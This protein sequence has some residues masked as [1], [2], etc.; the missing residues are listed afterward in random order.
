MRIGRIGM[1]MLLCLGYISGIYAQTF[2]KL[3]KQVEQAEKKSLPET[4]IKLTDKIYRKGEMEKNSPQ[5]LKAYMWRMKYRERIT[6]DSF[7]ISLK[8]LEEWVKHTDK[9]MDRA[10]LHSLLAGIYAD[11]AAR[12]QW[13]LRQQTDIVGVVPADMLNWTANI[14]VDTIQTHIRKAM[15]DSVL[16]L[17]TSSRT[18]IPFVELGET[19]EYYHHDMYHLLASRSI[20]ALLRVQYLDKQKNVKQHISGLY[21]NMLSAYRGKGDKESYV[22]TSLNF[23]KWKYESNY[24]FYPVIDKAAPY[25]LAE[26]PYIIDLNKLAADYKTLDICAEVLLAK[27]N[28]IL[29]RQQPFTALQVCEEAIRLYPDYR[30]INALKNL[31]EEIL[32][33]FL[34]VS[35]VKTAFPDQE[36]KIKVSHKNL[37]GFTIRIYREKK[38][39]SEQHY[40]VRR[41][42][43]YQSQDTTFTF[44]APGVG[45]YVMRIVP[46]VRAKKEIEKEFNVTHFYV[47]T[48]ELPKEQ[49]E[50][51]TLD[52]RTGHPIS[53]AQ[54]TLYNNKDV[55]LQMFTTN[56][57]GKAIFPWKSDYSYLIATKGDDT[58]MEKKDIRG[59]SFRS[60]DMNETTEKVILL[61]D[62]SL[63]RPGQTVYVK[64]IAYVSELGAARVLSDKEYTVSLQDNNNQEVGKRTLRTNEFGS[65]TTSFTLPLA[66]L[67][68]D[69]QLKTPVGNASIRVE[70]YKRPT[71]DIT[72]E[73]QE[74]D[75]QLGN[76]AEIKGKV[77]SY[78]G[79]LLRDLPVKYTIKR[80]AYSF[81]QLRMNDQ[82]ASGEVITGADGVFTIPVQLEGDTLYNNGKGNYFSYLIEITVTNAAG[83]TQTSTKV[84]SAGDTFLYLRTYLMPKTCKDDPIKLN[85]YASNQ[86]QLA[87]VTV[88]YRLYRAKDKSMKQL[89]DTPVITGTAASNKEIFLDWED[90][91]SGPYV[92][93]ISAE[94]SLGRKGSAETSTILY[95]VHNKRPPIQTPDWYFKTNTEFDA[96]HP[97]VFYFGTSEKDVCVMVDVFSNEAL[98]ESKVLHLSDSI[99]RFEFPYQASYGDGIAVNIYM[100]RD[101]QVYQ[102]RV[103]LSKRSLDEKLDMKWEVFRD[104]LRPGQK[105][106]WKLT[107]KNPQGKGADAEMLATMYDA[108]LDKIWKQGQTFNVFHYRNLPYISWMDNF[109]SSIWFEYEWDKKLFKVPSFEYDHFV[110]VPSSSIPAVVGQGVGEFWI[111]GIA[112][113]SQQNRAK[114]SQKMTGAVLEE[115]VVTTRSSSL[116]DDLAGNVP[117]ILEAEGETISPVTDDIRTNLAETAFFYPQLRTNEQGEVSFSFTMPESLTRWNFRGYSHTKNMMLGTLDGEAVTS[118]EFMLVPNLPR[119][120]RVGDK[121]SIAASISN[122]TGKVQSGTVSMILFDPM[123][124]K[125]ISTR[126]QEFKVEAGATIGVSFQF[127]VDD[128]YSILGCRMIADSKMFSDGEQQLIP[129]L[130]NKEHLIETLPMPIRGEETRTFSLDSLFNHHSATATDRKLTI[131]FTGNPSWY[132]IQ[133]LPSLSLPTNDNAISWANAYYANTLAAYIMNSQPRIKAVFDSWKLQGGTKETFLSNL[134]KNQEV[135]NILLSESPWI[136]EAQT[137]EQQKERIA[138]LF[139]LNNILSNN[140]AAL[141]R[142]QNLQNGDGAW[143]WYKGMNGSLY[144][145]TYIMELYARLFMLTGDKPTELALAMQQDAF[146]YLH[147]LALEEY[148]ATLEA[149][150]AGMK[151]T[152]LPGNMLDYLYLIAISGEKVPD[153]NKAAYDYFLSRVG[154]LLPSSSMKMK[155]LAAVVLDKAGRKKE[156]QEFIASLKEHLTKTDGQGM[157]FAFNENPFDWGSMKIQTHVDVMEALELIGGNEAIVEEMKLWLLAQKQTQQWKSPVASV[158][159]IYA[160]LMKGMN[161]LDNQGDV[162]ITIANEVLETI[163]PSKT[164]VTGLGYI[165]RS[166]TQKNVVNARTIKVQKRDQGIAWGAAYAEYESPIRDV[167]QQ[168]GALNVEKRLYV[169]RIVNNVPQLQPVTEKTNLQVGDKVVSRLS[170]RVD[171][172]MDFVQLKDQRGACFEPVGNISGY[173]W[174]NSIGYYVDIKDAST[175][176]FFDHLGKGAYVLEYSYYVTREGTYE[177]GLATIQCAYAP[178]Y[179]SHSASTEVVVSSSA[180]K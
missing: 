65:F 74:G 48:S 67:N 154:G 106:E 109:T 73:K 110:I 46:D 124:D 31:R 96:T 156:A 113:P 59:G 84:I 143:S 133:A 108:S 164:T 38:F 77:Q 120:V 173:R 51:I 118:K 49:Y 62:R 76:K 167:K 88:T 4:V 129:V 18:Y 69:F 9:P 151:M 140:S 111:R 147:K 43:N 33:P 149:Q 94:D 55:A 99:A 162:R 53:N 166:F 114:F 3:W 135:K 144:V 12:N 171:R 131:E 19:S 155:A 177:T 102:E 163:S 47:L 98:L 125:V 95:S 56:E 153:A 137:E 180:E 60:P 139:D 70:E 36:M 44:K 160:L 68:G 15:S 6:P 161:L 16:L 93:K 39:V 45:K 42:D 142:L 146:I 159:A 13:S 132:A 82:I 134:Q 30:R 78:S 11:Y 2:D 29:Q 10:I 100:V 115:S 112:S 86:G 127:T 75:Y 40:S 80:S 57:E 23:L 104:K 138:T 17:K 90:I 66:C 8:G 91:P 1:I 5:M 22:L 116:K 20:E 141:R 150:K 130:S 24:S 89:E 92:L 81:W 123:T 119:F 170:I 35:T 179:A 32:A 165:K 97:A 178:E 105:E 25:V 72:F 103:G 14:F 101:G 34:S 145:T 7:Y 54:V 175:N 136:L 61:T 126:K 64:G 121:T 41:P 63:Y 58:F 83:E 71:F 85:F 168:G 158:D 26:D 87:D 122:M 52:A 28:L 169:E 37:D 107:I 148:Q 128:Q 174:D 27:A 117:G 152:G 176:F 50:V 157:S 79:V 21:D 172:P